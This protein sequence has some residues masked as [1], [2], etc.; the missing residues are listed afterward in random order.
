MTKKGEAEFEKSQ[1]YL[2]ICSICIIFDFVEGTLARKNPNKFGFLLAYS[3]LCTLKK[4]NGRK[5]SKNGHNSN[6]ASALP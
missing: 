2:G 3:Y 4:E 6:T 5:E 1:I